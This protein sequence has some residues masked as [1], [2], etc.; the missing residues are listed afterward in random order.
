MPVPSKSLVF[1]VAT[2]APRERAI[3]AIWRSACENRTARSPSFGRDSG[4]RARSF[5][6][7]GQHAILEQL[8]E[9]DA[10]P[11]TSPSFSSSNW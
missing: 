3:A 10:A 11:Q 8:F 7:K 6:L 5:T 9:S 4:I 2:D 1:R